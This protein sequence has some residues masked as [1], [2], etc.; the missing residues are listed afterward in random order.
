MKNAACILL[1]PL[2]VYSCLPEEK[3]NDALF[4]LLPASVTH[5]DFINQLTENEQFNIIDYLYFNNGAGVAAGDINNDGLTDIYFTSNQ[6]PNKLYLNRGNLRFEDITEKAGVTRK[7]VWKTG[8]IMLDV[9][10]GGLLDIYVCQGIRIQ[11][12]W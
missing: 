10:G 11:A 9:I 4:S 3:E 8:V 7:W 6:G 1:V 12:F 5:V 2:L